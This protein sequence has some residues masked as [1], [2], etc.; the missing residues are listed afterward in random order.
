[1]ESIVSAS[2]SSLT[3][4]SSSCNSSGLFPR[5]LIPTGTVTGRAD[6]RFG[7]F[8][9]ESPCGEKTLL[10]EPGTQLIPTRQLNR[11]AVSTTYLPF[12]IILLSGFE[13][14][15]KSALRPT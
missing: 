7:F 1:M 3:L 6:P 14:Q 5:T 9:E 4:R 10:P 13:C 15:G 2:P 12:F 11:A 8:D